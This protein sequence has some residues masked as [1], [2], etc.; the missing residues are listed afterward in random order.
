MTV[1]DAPPH[2]DNIRNVAQSVRSGIDVG[3]AG[4]EQIAQLLELCADRIQQQQLE[5]VR[6]RA[7]VRRY[8]ED[9]QND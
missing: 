4:L 5:L 7:R 8:Q 6:V 3:T 2:P 9:N 1:Y